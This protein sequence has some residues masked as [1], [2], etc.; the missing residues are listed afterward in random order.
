MVIYL[1]GKGLR[2][3]GINAVNL[4]TCI[5]RKALHHYVVKNKG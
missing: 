1:G 5:N 4:F 2:K 3:E